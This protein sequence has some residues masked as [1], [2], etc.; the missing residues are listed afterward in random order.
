MEQVNILV[1]RFQPLTL[2]HMKCVDEAWNKYK[3]PTVLCMID[4]QLNKTDS[5]HPFPST[6]LFPLY[7]RIIKKFSKIKDIILVKNAD[8]VQISEILK[9]FGYQI[10][11]WTCG[12]DR[13]ADYK[14]MIKDYGHKANLAPSCDVLEVN[15]PA[16]ALSATKVRQLIKD[17][18]LSEFCK[19]TPWGQSIRL[20]TRAEKDFNLLKTW[21]DRRG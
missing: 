5:K 3:L 6:I 18:N 7:S 15:R 4:T 1:G 21:I 11:C 8:I 2:G 16:D 20:R 13:A 12:S 14:R 10:A 19:S 9:G 17:G